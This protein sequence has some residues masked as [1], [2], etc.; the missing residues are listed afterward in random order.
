VRTNA[1]LEI[2]ARCKVELTFHF[3]VRQTEEV[4]AMGVRDGCAKVVR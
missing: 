2:H 3:M 1:R 4:V